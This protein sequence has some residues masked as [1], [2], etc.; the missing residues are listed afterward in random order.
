[1]NIVV[2]GR[3]FGKECKKG[4]RLCNCPSLVRGTSE[5]EGDGIRIESNPCHTERNIV[6]PTERRDE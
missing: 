1:M 4:S 6:I 2:T 5:A 3:I